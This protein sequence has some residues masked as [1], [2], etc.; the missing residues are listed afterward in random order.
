MIA[1][2]NKATRSP[3]S[4]GDQ[5]SMADQGADKLC[6]DY[7]VVALQSCDCH[8]RFNAPREF[9]LLLGVI[10]KLCKQGFPERRK[11]E[12]PTPV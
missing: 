8:V 9:V 6:T 4:G 1:G 7:Q 3:E 11:V 10:S 12:T 5:A 2:S